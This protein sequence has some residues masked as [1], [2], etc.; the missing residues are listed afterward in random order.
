MKGGIFINFSCHKKQTGFS[1]PSRLL[2]NYTICD[3]VS[4]NYHNIVYEV[5]SKSNDKT[6]ILK[7]LSRK[8]FPKTLY[9]KI[10]SLD[11]AF[12]LLPVEK[13][14][15]KKY[16]YLVFPQY[17]TLSD[18][19]FLEGLTCD[20]LKQFASDIGQAISALHKQGILH[21]DIRPQN[22][23]MDSAKHFYLLLLT[24]A[25]PLSLSR[26]LQEG[27]CGQ[28]PVLFL[29]PQ[30]NTI[31]LYNPAILIY[32]AMPYFCLCC[33]MMET[34]LLFTKSKTRHFVQKLTRSFIVFCF[35]K[36]TPSLQAKI[37]FPP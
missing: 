16:V 12:L 21:L 1:M 27:I 14:D 3:I 10:F 37:Q 18:I 8:Y 5:L 31:F 13:Y 9:D 28:A 15:D 33:C 2:Q 30:K 17:K 26:F 32:I 29:L 19:L 7:I 20:M 35:Q 22:I 4:V 11:N 6:Y 25:V 24:P 23:F 36:K 34:V